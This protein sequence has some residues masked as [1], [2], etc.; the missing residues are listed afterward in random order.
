MQQKYSRLK[1]F[2]YPEKIASLPPDNPQILPPLHLRIKPTNACNHSCSY[3]AYRVDDLQLG[4]DMQVRDQIPWEKMQEIIEDIS[5]MGVKGV[6]FSGGGEPFVYPHLLKTVQLLTAAGIKFAALTNG[7][8]LE[9]E[10]SEYFARHATWIRVSMD[11]WDDQSYVHFRRARNGEYTRITQNMRSFL[12]FKGPC[13]LGVSLIVSHDNAPHVYDF[14]SAM[15]DLGVK[16]I[17]VSPCIVSNNGVEN[18]EYHKPVFE[19]VKDQV[20]RAIETLAGEDFEIFDAYH[21]LEEKFTKKY[22]WCP[23]LQVLA[24]IGADQNVYP[25]QDK[26]YN[27]KDGLLGSLKN[28][29]FRD[30]WYSDKAV[31]YKINPSVVCNHHCVANG[32]NQMLHEFLSLDPEHIGFV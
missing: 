13:L 10:I 30:F 21:E 29:R 14:V 3:C 16:S 4:Q 26:A 5:T 2:H 9:G 25:C 27:L 20:R 19:N 17:K 18:N 11:G 7:G 32:K 22:T 28:Q 1:V 8:R 31:F 24:V 12:A 6:T 23:Y 15:H